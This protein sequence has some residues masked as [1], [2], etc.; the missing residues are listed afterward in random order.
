MSAAGNSL[1]ERSVLV[2]MLDGIRGSGSFCT[3]GSMPFMFPGICLPDGEEL[4]LPLSES[5]ARSIASLAEAAPFGKGEQT[6]YDE[7][8]RKCRQLDA[9]DLDWSGAVEWQHLLD[10][11]VAVVRN[12]LGI[13]GKISAQAYK[14]LLYEPGGFFLPHRDTEKLGNMFGSLIVAL[15]SKHSGGLLRVRH[16]G[17]ETVADFSSGEGL[18]RIQYAAFFA[19]CEHD[20][21]VVESGYRLC[22]A[23]NLVLEKGDPER[24]NPRLSAQSKPLAAVLQALREVRGIGALV[25]SD[26]DD[27]N[28]ADNS[29]EPMDRRTEDLLA[30]TLRHRYTRENLSFASLK[31]DDRARAAALVAA[32]GE[33]GYTAHLALLTLHQMGELEGGGSY[34]GHRYYDYEED[35]ELF[36]DSQ[37]SMGEIFDEELYLEAW[38]DANDDEAPLGSFAIGPESVLSHVEIGS[39]EP[40]QKESEGYTGNAGC[41][42]DYWYHRAV[43]VLWPAA[44]DARIR[45]DYDFCGA[46]RQLRQLADQGGPAAGESREFR[47]LASAAVCHAA[48]KLDSANQSGWERRHCSEDSRPLLEA[49]AGAA[50]RELLSECRNAGLLD[51]WLEHGDSELWQK[52]F[53][54]FGSS[55]CLDV[56]ER[57]LSGDAKRFAV[58]L[59]HALNALLANNAD[60]GDDAGSATLRVIVAKLPTLL[61]S[62][63]RQT[64]RASSEDSLEYQ[65]AYYLR[66][67][68][69][70]PE[71]IGRQPVDQARIDRYHS[72]IAASRF[73][74]GKEEGKRHRNE[75]FRQLAGASLDD[76]RDVLAPALLGKNHRQLFQ[77][78]NSLHA[79]LLADA[80]ARL[81]KEIDEPLQAYPDQARPFPKKHSGKAGPLIAELREFLLDPVAESHRFKRNEADRRFLQGFIARHRLD[82]TTETERSGRPY[83]LVCTKTDESYRRAV[84]RR[85][86][87][88]RLVKKLQGM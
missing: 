64:S 68:M 42:M 40:D 35:E 1:P 6:V 77:H 51:D 36:D 9:G 83:T 59:L 71:S 57:F 21:E 82:V 34:R 66:R 25:A 45:V 46:C 80:I 53:V 19:D 81:K 39:G 43:V 52:V 23:Y 79:K 11:I 29:L 18:R 60:G 61:A 49:V 16:D 47:A 3:V 8:V 31:N 13:D 74:D 7:S 87:D 69:P 12:E 48:E 70:V 4:A 56:I 5:Q 62:A 2:E 28:K 76:L 88:E 86:D 22:L 20:V 58:P 15:P 84:K 32:A 38:R 85:K 26:S 30:V 10:A 17:R 54:A 75:L 41:T 37:G 27:E 24:L 50:D 63:D 73:I 78:R 14:L 33:A 72:A 44:N 67:D 55:S 65:Y